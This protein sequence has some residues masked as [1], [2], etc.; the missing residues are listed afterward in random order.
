MVKEEGGQGGGGMVGD[1][2]RGRG[3]G[4]KEGGGCEGGEG[5]R[6]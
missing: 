5:G 1:V 3:E 6:I 2:R 4:V